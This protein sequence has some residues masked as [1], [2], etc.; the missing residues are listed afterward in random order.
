MIIFLDFFFFPTITSG[1]QQTLL[2]RNDE[3][4]PI[5]RSVGL[6][7]VMRAANR[8]QRWRTEH[9]EDGEG[10]IPS[11]FNGRM[12]ELKD[13]ETFKSFKIILR[14]QANLAILNAQ[15][16]SYPSICSYQNVYIAES[17]CLSSFPCSNFVSPSSSFFLPRITSRRCSLIYCKCSLI[18]DLWF[19]ETK[20]TSKTS[21]MNDIQFM[22]AQLLL[23][24]PHRHCR[25][26]PIAD[27]RFA[28]GFLVGNYIRLYAS[29]FKLI[30]LE[31][32]YNSLSFQASSPHRSRLHIDCNRSHFYRSSS[33]SGGMH[34]GGIKFIFLN[35]NRK[36]YRTFQIRPT[37]NHWWNIFEYL[38][39][40]SGRRVREVLPCLRYDSE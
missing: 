13:S 3:T 36:S 32:W 11:T 19:P 26:S 34:E 15:Y 22:E 10:I 2:W 23:H 37:V 8:T 30:H 25:P 24:S 17:P 12:K 18:F 1:R 35:R 5:C 9:L 16:I 28:Q 20:G 7:I 4:Q 6:I 39:W 14:F 31:H 33:R 38:A 29:R 27:A 21:F 40:L